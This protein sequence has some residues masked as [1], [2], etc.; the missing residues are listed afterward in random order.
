[1]AV[2]VQTV[3]AVL[4]LAIALLGAVVEGLGDPMV[5]Q[6]SVIGILLSHGATL[7]ILSD[8]IKSLRGDTDAD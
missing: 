8:K 4:F 5:W 6:Y 2:K 3:L 7:G 1:M